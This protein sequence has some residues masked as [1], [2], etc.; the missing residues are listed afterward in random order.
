MVLLKTSVNKQNKKS[1]S[2]K[3]CDKHALTVI[4]TIAHLMNV[5]NFSKKFDPFLSNLNMAEYKGQNP[6]Y[7]LLSGKFLNIMKGDRVIESLF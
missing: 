2:F 3:Y 1:I 5:I 7:L 4:H 6:F